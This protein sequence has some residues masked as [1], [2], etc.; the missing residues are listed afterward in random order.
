MRDPRCPLE[1]LG[2]RIVSDLQDFAKL[3]KTLLDAACFCSLIH[4]SKQ[5]SCGRFIQYIHSNTE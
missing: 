1:H 3:C 5:A 4:A 2:G